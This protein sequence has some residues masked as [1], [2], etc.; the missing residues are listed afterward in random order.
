MKSMSCISRILVMGGMFLFNSTFGHALPSPHDLSLVPIQSGGRVKPLAVWA[1]EVVLEVTGTLSWKGEP[2]L[3]TVLH[4]MNDP[5]ETQSIAMIKIGVPELRR[6]LLLEESQSRFS[7][8]ELMKNPAFLQYA[9]FSLSEKGVS[10]ETLAQAA[11]VPEKGSAG[12]A[13]ARDRELKLLIGR[14]SALRAL[15]SGEAWTLLPSLDG[16]GAAWDSLANREVHDR[17]PNQ[18]IVRAFSRLLAA[19]QEKDAVA[20]S[21]AASELR[22][23][24]L[25]AGHINPS[26]ASRLEWEYRYNTQNPFLWAACAYLLAAVAFFILIRSRAANGHWSRKLGFL[27]LVSGFL[28]HT[29]GFVLRSVISG[30]PPVSNMYESVIWVSYGLIVF[31]AVIY[32]VQKQR[33][34]SLLSTASLLAAFALYVADS[35]PAVLDPHIHPLVPVLRSNLWLTIHVLTITLGYSALALTFGLSWITLGHFVLRNPKTGD[36]RTKAIDTSNFLLYRAMQIGVVLLAAGTILGGVWADYSWGRFWG[37]DPKE[38]WALIALLVYIAILHG[39]MAGWVSP[40][41]FALVSNLGF[42]SVLMAWYGV[43]FV[44]GVGLHSYGFSSGGSGAV[45]MVCLFSII[46]LTLIGVRERAREGQFQGK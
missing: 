25:N 1:Q 22:T 27:A 29:Y 33:S 24:V 38:V 20:Y 13:S 39:R 10:D 26:D 23:L 34:F 32:W 43:N 7:Y 35:S 6:Q 8:E 15:I 4:W 12:R 30:R 5:K 9:S 45:A 42:L 18:S 31:A 21:S 40:F 46:A 16:E 2:A 3:E 41:R 14:V 36:L 11:V 28:I 19:D 17:E 37:W 44:L